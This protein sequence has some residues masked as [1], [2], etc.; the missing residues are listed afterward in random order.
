M[1]ICIIILIVSTVSLPH[2]T[3]WLCVIPMTNGFSA[4]P[5]LQSETTRGGVW[6]WPRFVSAE[7]QYLASWWSKLSP[8]VKAMEMLWV[9]VPWNSTTHPIAHRQLPPHQDG[10]PMSSPLNN[11]HPPAPPWCYL[12]SSSP[13]GHISLSNTYHPSHTWHLLAGGQGLLAVFMV[14]Y[15]GGVGG[16]RWN[17][18]FRGHVP[19]MGFWSQRVRWASGVKCLPPS[20][21]GMQCVNINVIRIEFVLARHIPNHEDIVC[22]RRGKELG[23]EQGRAWSSM[24]LMEN[25]RSPRISKFRL[26]TCH[27]IDSHTCDNSSSSDL[28]VG[29][30]KGSKS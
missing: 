1:Y 2:E 30:F 22:Q 26:S 20:I 15:E 19:Q 7:S 6:L 12:P 3:R 4:L 16:L 9:N 14:P 24:W 17:E 27:V 25:F 18:W 29:G 8:S 5:Q 23:G 10:G 13:R 21:A 11:P 28:I